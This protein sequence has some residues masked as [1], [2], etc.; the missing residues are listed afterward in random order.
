MQDT[1][2]EMLH[3]RKLLFLAVLQQAVR[4]AV[5]EGA[6]QTSCVGFIYKLFGKTDKFLFYTNNNYHYRGQHCI[7]C[8]MHGYKHLANFRPT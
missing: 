3:G 8:F 4:V 5:S 6:G 1:S 2:M 7:V